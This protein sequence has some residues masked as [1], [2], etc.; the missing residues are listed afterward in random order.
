MFT[1]T[2]L[3]RPDDYHARH[4]SK[5]KFIQV[6][7][8]GIRLLITKSCSNTIYAYTREGKTDFWPQISNI[9]PVAELIK[10]IPDGTC[11]D[12]ELHVPGVPETSMKTFLLAGDKRVVLTPFAVP[13]FGF[14]DMRQAS[15][16]AVNN[17]IT[18]M[19]FIP[20]ETHDAPPALE[21]AYIETLLEAARHRKIEG[22]VLKAAHY[23][24]WWKLKPVKTVD[25][26]VEM[27]ER[28][29]G[30]HKH[31]MGAIGVC[32][33]EPSKGRIGISKILGK[34]TG[35]WSCR[36][37]TGFTDA[38]RDHI[39]QDPDRVLGKVVEI[40]YDSLAANGALKF[41]RFVRFR[42]DKEPAQCVPAQIH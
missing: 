10:T 35:E 33:Y 28:G 23:E 36:V 14:E 9:E 31:R 15:I 37:G 19:G 38:E 13:M 17:L 29:E 42:D 3:L 20:P 24:G 11:L 8:N 7:Y 5:V 39:W 40:A 12:C 32:F 27:V 1:H 21:T 18:T 16:G 22:F 2:D 25:C 41:P 6:K 4:M 26:I 30:K 34:P